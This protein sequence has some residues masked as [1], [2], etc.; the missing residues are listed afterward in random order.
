[1]SGMTWN[2][3][4]TA[5]KCVTFFST[6][7]YKLFMT[8]AVVFDTWFFFLFWIS[9]IIRINI[10][11]HNPYMKFFCFLVFYEKIPQQYFAL[12]S[13]TI[14]T[15]TKLESII[16]HQKNLLWL[17]IYNNNN[18]LFLPPLDI[19]PIY[20]K[21]LFVFVKHSNFPWNKQPEKKF[22]HVYRV[23]D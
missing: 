16:A 15:K 5:I 4:K 18:N 3:N 12:V 10:N 9:N 20:E 21:I 13:Y 23:C 19:L 2:G 7:K 22:L 17:V 6:K 11:I 8:H 1:M 14:Y